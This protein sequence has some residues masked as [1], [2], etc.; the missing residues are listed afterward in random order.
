LAQ[1]FLGGWKQVMVLFS[2]FHSKAIRKISQV[3]GLRD[4]R[5]VFV[6]LSFLGD[7]EK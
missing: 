6:G 7:C 3:E 5:C 4:P 1:V 2:C